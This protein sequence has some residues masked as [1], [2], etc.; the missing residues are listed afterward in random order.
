M[1]L[2]TTRADELVDPDVAPEELLFRLFHEDGV[3]VFEAQYVRAACSCS[4]D[5]IEAVLSRYNADELKDMLEKG[6][7]RVTC[8]FCR[9][10]YR[11]DEV[12]RHIQ[13]PAANA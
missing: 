3:R 13:H 1:L 9:T 8:E 11:F 4:A 5:K 6:A 10:E 12:G 7:I 2:D